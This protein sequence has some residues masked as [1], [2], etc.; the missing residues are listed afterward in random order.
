MVVLV[1]LKTAGLA[2][3]S[4]AIVAVT[5]IFLVTKICALEESQRPDS[6]DFVKSFIGLWCK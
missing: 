4:A 5:V 1:F 6:I 3:G 2:S